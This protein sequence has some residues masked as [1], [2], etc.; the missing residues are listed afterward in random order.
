MS[1]ELERRRLQTLKRSLPRS[2]DIIALGVALF[3][4]RLSFTHLFLLGFLPLVGMWLFRLDKHLFGWACMLSV[5]LVVHWGVLEMR[6]IIVPKEGTIIHVEDTKHT[7]KTSE[8]TFY[9]YVGT[10]PLK[11]GSTVRADFLLLPESKSSLIGGFDQSKYL[12]SQNIRGTLYAKTVEVTD[13]TAVHPGLS[14][15]V[16]AYIDREFTTLKPYMT[17]FFLGSTEG[18]DEDL[19]TPIR[20]LG[21]A[22]IF[23]VSGLHVGLLAVALEL[24]LKKIPRDIR[25]VI[26][27]G[28]LGIYLLLTD[29]SVSLMR[30]SLLYVFIQLNHRFNGTLTP[31]DGLGLLIIGS[32]L[33]TPNV[34]FQPAFLLS[35]SVTLILLLMAP[36]LSLKGAP[37]RV[38]IYAFMT[39]LPL[40]MMMSGSVNLSS[41][42]LNIIA[43]IVLGFYLLPLSYLTFFIPALEGIIAPLFMGFE[44][45]LLWAHEWVYIPVSVPFTF[46]VF[47]F[48]YYAGWV[49]ILIASKGSLYRLI[50]GSS[51][52]IAVGFI[53]SSLS[54]YPVLSVL[55]VDG[56]SFLYQAPMNHCN[57]LIDG[58]TEMTSEALKTHL[59]NHGINHFHVI[60]TTHDDADHAD[61]IEV[62]MNDPYFSWDDHITPENLPET[63]S[64][65]DAQLAFDQPT[66]IYSSKNEQSVV[67]TLE[68]KGWMALFTGDI[69][70]LREAEFVKHPLPSID[71]LKVSHHGSKS[72]TSDAFLDHVNPQ[73]AL[74]NLPH[75]NRF[76]FPSDDVIARLESR[77]IKI[78]RTDIH[79]TTRFIIGPKWTLSLPAFWP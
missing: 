33:V 1:Q 5:L 9:L 36:T 12:K 4:V 16:Q 3:I 44:T 77:D 21:I 26:I 75:A 55:D 74:I 22:H 2:G 73:V 66:R 54:F 28:I 61:G 37:V 23:A 6:P 68:R 42:F 38:S 18:F 7:L 50:T 41:I 71:V 58:G 49:I 51:T 31:L 46:G 15:K 65:G 48:F 78:F 39:T 76:D 63:L 64:C 24:L 11:P 13:Y 19:I 43:V 27:G 8:G 72:S 10:P 70:A 62:L 34:I 45:M 29:F 32:L 40:I 57:V 17:A 52:L 53:V 14:Q 56:D 30:A 60:I 67:V 59:K 69:E 20:E 79:G 47:M 35:Y 25:L